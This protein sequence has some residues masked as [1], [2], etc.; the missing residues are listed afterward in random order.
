MI[1]LATIGVVVAVL[2]FFAWMFMLL[3]NWI[4]P[5]LFGWPT[6]TYWMAWGIMILASILFG[7]IRYNR[8]K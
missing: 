1:V 3:W 5:Y 4:L 8:N 7:G 6:I 2:S